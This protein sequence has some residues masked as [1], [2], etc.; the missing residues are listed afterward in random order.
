MNLKNY[1]NKGMSFNEYDAHVKDVIENGNKEDSYYSYYE[2]NLRR[3]ERIY[4]TLKISE[5]QQ[6]AIKNID[7]KVQFIIITEGWCG[8]ASQILPV[9]QRFAELNSNLSTRYF[10]R[11][12][13]EDLMNNYLT[14]GAKSIPIIVGVDEESGEEIFKWG[15]R[16]AWGSDLLASYKNEE[17]TKD[18]FVLAVQKQYN[19]D[20]GVSIISEILKLI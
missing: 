18:E 2:M 10:L 1:V 20:K 14:N 13:E 6:E 15:P 4:K 19:K 5:A 12:S 11:D 3:S 9:V 16:P 8:D 17:M 7:K